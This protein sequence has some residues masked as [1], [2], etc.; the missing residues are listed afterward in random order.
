MKVM[1][2]LPPL[3]MLLGGCAGS[4]W[5]TMGMSD[6]EFY[7]TEIKPKTLEAVCQRLAYA[8]SQFAGMTRGG[9]WGPDAS[10]LLLERLRRFS[11]QRSVEA[12]Y[13][14]RYCSDPGLYRQ[15]RE[16]EQRQQ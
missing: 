11:K 14:Q 8:E 15:K 10:V 4:P 12:G 16:W 9:G 7:E 5:G 13:D 1:L 3:V 2:L 6:Q